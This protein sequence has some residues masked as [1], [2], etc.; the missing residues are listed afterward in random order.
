AIVFTKGTG[1]R[2]SQVLSPVLDTTLHRIVESCM[3]MKPSR[4]SRTLAYTMVTCSLLVLTGCG[5]MKLVPVSGTATLDGKPLSQCTVSFNPDAAKGNPH[6]ISCIG[7]LD[8][9]GHFQLKTIAVRG[10]EGGPGAP[11]GWYKVTLL[12]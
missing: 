4:L 8:G 1:P 2:T 6:T 5:G 9:Q 12:T 7:R 10:S 3:S 11:L